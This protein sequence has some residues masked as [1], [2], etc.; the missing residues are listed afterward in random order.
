[1]EPSLILFIL[2]FWITFLYGMWFYSEKY[3]TE[4]PDTE[5]ELFWV[6]MVIY[7]FFTSSLFW[8]F[9]VFVQIRAKKR[10]EQEEIDRLR[11]K[12]N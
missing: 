10:S 12:T 11:S 9:M 6:V 3:A 1:M 2:Y 7:S 8:P 5:V 4:K